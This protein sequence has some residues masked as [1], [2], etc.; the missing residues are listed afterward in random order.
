MGGFPL[1]RYFGGSDWMG[2]G[3]DF[4]DFLLFR[5]YGGSD[6]MGVGIDLGGFPLFRYFGDWKGGMESKMARNGMKN[7]IGICG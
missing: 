6:G 2:T 1:Y 3:I 7:G 4:D 5:Y